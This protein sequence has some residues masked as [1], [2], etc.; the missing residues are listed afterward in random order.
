VIS[1]AFRRCSI[2]GAPAA[3]KI[4]QRGKLSRRIL[5]PLLVLGVDTPRSAWMRGHLIE[6]AE[7]RGIA[8]A[9]L[10][11][12]DRL[13]SLE[14]ALAS[15]DADA[16]AVCADPREQAI[17]ASV[18][19]ARD[20]PYTCIAAGT[21]DLLARDLGAAMDDPAEALALLFS[22]EERLIDL[23]EVNGVMF[24]NYVA[25]GLELE[26]RVARS[27]RARPRA[28]GAP[29]EAA[30]VALP[31][32]AAPGAGPLGPFAR[33]LVSNN[34]FRLRPGGLGPRAWPDAGV[35]GVAVCRTREDA[36]ERRPGE[37][38]W[39]ECSCARVELAASAPVLANVD[40]AA[41]PLQPPLRFRCVSW[42]L[43]VLV[44]DSA[45]APARR[46]R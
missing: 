8:I 29:Q 16:V 32:L 2:G 9:T 40:G 27:W 15:A 45:V 4:M 1:A 7:R 25:L 36:P 11:A 43:R 37:A 31:G 13:R 35:L 33:V 38:G 44:P 30:R 22:S 5:H 19:S 14:R 46:E 6:E 17:V 34:R 24:V 26:H 23:A 20:V 3:R 41:L 28:A 21:D 12:E 39:Y 18:A 10:P 42:A